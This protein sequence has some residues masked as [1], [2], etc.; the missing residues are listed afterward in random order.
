M[1]SP[2]LLR[3][4]PARQLGLVEGDDRVLVFG[5]LG[6]RYSGP[7]PLAHL[8]T[9]RRRCAE[10]NAQVEILVFVDEPQPDAATVARI[11]DMLAEFEDGDALVCYQ[12]ATEAMKVIESGKV[13]RGV[14]RSSLLAV[15]SPEVVRRRALERAMEGAT[16]TWVNPTGLIADSGGDIRLFPKGESQ[17]RLWG[18]TGEMS[19]PV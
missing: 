10:L 7:T 3:P 15:R 14:D 2:H 6:G 5:V 9:L 11:D 1:S 8:P 16:D 19:H 4:F 18:E 17:Q 12:P 13:V